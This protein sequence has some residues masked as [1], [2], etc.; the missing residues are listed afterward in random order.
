MASQYNH[1][2]VSYA[3]LDRIKLALR[4]HSD[5]IKA[6]AFIRHDRFTEAELKDDG[7][8]P[9]PHF[10]ILVRL[11]R[12]LSQNTVRRWFWD[13]DDDGRLVNTLNRN[14]G[15]V[16]VAYDYLIH[17]WDP[18]KYQYSP[19][20][21]VVSD[22][23]WFEIDECIEE[24]PAFLA[25]QMALCD[26]EPY[27]IAKRLGKDFLYHSRS[28]YESVRFQHAWEAKHRYNG[29]NLLRYDGN[30]VENVDYLK[31]LEVIK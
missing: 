26:V 30:G 27:V 2:L 1:S 17:K 28:I 9:E 24:N 7:T 14:V 12:R 21:R 22:R 6:Y 5:E 11:W 4:E 13:L 20:D 18:E 25:Y 10:H 29:R 31:E 19:A 15:S 16:P 3:T 23:K 8:E